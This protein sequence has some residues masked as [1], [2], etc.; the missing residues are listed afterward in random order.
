MENTTLTKD[1]KF[2]LNNGKYMHFSHMSFFDNP[3]FLL[4]DTKRKLTIVDS[5]IHT[6]SNDDE[7]DSPVKEEYQAKVLKTHIYN[8]FKEIFVLKN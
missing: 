4:E 7:P 3:I 1:T 6:A 8:F 5:V 2:E